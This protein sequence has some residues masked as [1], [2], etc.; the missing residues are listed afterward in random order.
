MESIQKRLNT[1]RKKDNAEAKKRETSPTFPNILFSAQYK[2]KRVV[3]KLLKTLRK[4]Y[5]PNIVG[6]CGEFCNFEANIVI[7]GR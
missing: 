6:N 1:G 5:L 7:L 4:I 3:N 2:Q